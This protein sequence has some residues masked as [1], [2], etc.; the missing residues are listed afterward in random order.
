MEFRETGFSSFSVFPNCQVLGLRYTGFSFFFV[1]KLS[2]VGVSPHGVFT[3][4]RF[5]V[6]GVFATRA[7][8]FSKFPSV[9][10]SL[11]EVSHFWGFQAV[12]C[13]SFVAREFTF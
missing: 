11:N 3:F 2:S 7:F 6:F 1:F 8:C 12:K 4:S 9:E 5:R 10:V 13:W